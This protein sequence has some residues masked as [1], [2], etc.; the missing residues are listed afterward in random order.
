MR[1]ISTTLLIVLLAP[2]VTASCNG[3]G[4]G[5]KTEDTATGNYGSKTE[6]AAPVNKLSASPGKESKRIVS[7]VISFASSNVRYENENPFQKTQ[8]EIAVSAWKGQRINAQILVWPS[9]NLKGFSATASPFK[10]TGTFSSSAVDIGFVRYVAA[11]KSGGVCGK[12]PDLPEINVA[13][14]ISNQ[15]SISLSKNKLQPVWISVDVPRN[16][17]GGTYTSKIT[18]SSEDNGIFDTLSLKITVNNHVLPLPANWD[19]FL[20]LSQFPLSEARYYKLTPWSAEHF[21]KIRPNMKQLAD[22]GQKVITTSFFWDPFSMESA[23]WGEENLMIRIQKNADGQFSYDFTNFDKWVSF[24][25]GLGINKQISV[26]GLYPFNNNFEFYFKDVKQSYGNDAKSAKANN[27]QAGASAAAQ[28]LYTKQSFALLSNDYNSFWA[29]L[30]KAF[31]AH[32]KQKGWFDRT[33]L[34]FDERPAK[35]TTDVI[36]F[37]RKTV[38]DFKVGYAGG[39]HPEFMAE[40]DYFS[41]ASYLIIPTDVLAQRQKQGKVTSY[42]TCCTE[43]RPNIFTYSDPA[44]GVFLGWYAIAN[45]YAGYM[46][47]AYDQWSTTS[48]TDTRHPLVPAGD[49]MIVYPDNNTSIRFQKLL[50]GIQDFQKI[51]LLRAEWV[52]SNQRDKVAKIDAVLG[53]FKRTSVGSISDYKQVVEDAQQVIDKLDN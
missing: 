35:Q 14:A 1:K 48:A 7:A 49:N 11:N 45:N 41:I 27:A 51:K 6:E 25:M 32:L 13:D 42:Y 43:K 33:V 17:P 4:T 36:Q 34:F 50:E 40:V 8:S 37:V 18:F 52:K 23:K 26:Y 15:K 38:P 24:M 44:E 22:A 46:R 5:E 3:A 28:K 53:R 39:Y 30:L 9:A 47:Y 21:A 16:I 2:A 31:A 19:F 12:I 29:G 10:G 20:D